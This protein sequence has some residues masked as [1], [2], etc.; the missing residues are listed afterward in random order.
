MVAACSHPMY[1]IPIG[2]EI[3]KVDTNYY[4]PT[5]VDLLIG[6]ATKCKEKLHW[7]PK[8]TLQELIAEMMKSDIELFQKE[9]FLKQ[10]GYKILNRKE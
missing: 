4:R 1:Q 5:E 10:G 8:H 2:K 3:I 9:Q 7:Q 6:D